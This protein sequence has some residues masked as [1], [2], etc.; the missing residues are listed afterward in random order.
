[1]AWL[2]GIGWMEMKKSVKEGDDGAP[3]GSSYGGIFVEGWV[4]NDALQVA[5]DEQRLDKIP[6]R[7]KSYGNES[8]LP[9]TVTGSRGQ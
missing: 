2:T 5:I 3:T 9:L 1:M 4:L 7:I 8:G 6:V